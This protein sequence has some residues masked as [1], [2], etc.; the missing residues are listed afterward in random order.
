MGN[1]TRLWVYFFPW[2]FLSWEKTDVFFVKCQAIAGRLADKS[3]TGEN[4]EFLRK[5]YWFLPGGKLKIF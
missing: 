2:E 5:S 3:F 4:G 1:G